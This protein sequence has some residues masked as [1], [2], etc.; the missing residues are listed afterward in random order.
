MNAKQAAALPRSRRQKVADLN[1]LS[2]CL[3]CAFLDTS[4]DSLGLWSEL[5]RASSARFPLGFDHISARRRVKCAMCKG[6]THDA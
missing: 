3:R 6:C 2:R 1:N 5:K 4:Y